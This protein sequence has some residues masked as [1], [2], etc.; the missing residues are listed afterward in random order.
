[1]KA[2]LIGKFNMVGLTRL[3]FFS[4][5]L[6]TPARGSEVAAILLRVK[7]GDHAKMTA[8]SA[9]K[10]QTRKSNKGSVLVEVLIALAI[11]S[12]GISAVLLLSSAN[13]DLKVDSQTNRPPRLNRL[14]NISYESRTEV[15]LPKRFK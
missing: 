6:A 13:Q 5:I 12:L 10:R 3:P 14:V 15:R 7:R 1:M 9:Q 2:E 8:K 4:L 11:L